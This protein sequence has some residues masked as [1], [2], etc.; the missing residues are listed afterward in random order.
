MSVSLI[1]A[2]CITS[3]TSDLLEDPSPRQNLPGTSNNV[4]LSL[5][6][7]TYDLPMQAM[8]FHIHNAD[9]AMYT[10]GEFFYVEK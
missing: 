8:T 3:P 7:T 4:S 6:K 1:L 10:H 9:D 5:E 2:S